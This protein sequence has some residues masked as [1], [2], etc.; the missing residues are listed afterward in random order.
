[1]SIYGHS[2]A[3]QTN[4]RVSV[5]VGPRGEAFSVETRQAPQISGGDL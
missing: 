5:V 2:L 4:R 1:M 3:L